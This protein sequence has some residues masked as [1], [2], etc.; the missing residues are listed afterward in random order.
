M[1]HARPLSTGSNCLQKLYEFSLKE[2][3]SFSPKF[4]IPLFV[5]EHVCV[6]FRF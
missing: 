5:R 4:D 6:R 2:M 3:S 1:N